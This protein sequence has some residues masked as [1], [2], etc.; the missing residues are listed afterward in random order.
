MRRT[1]LSQ[2]ARSAL[3]MVSASSFVSLV[4][5]LIAGWAI[6]EDYVKLEDTN[7]R[8][9]LIIII[10]EFVAQSQNNSLELVRKQ[11]DLHDQFLQTKN[12]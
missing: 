12:L 11:T 5:M 1:K 8:F 10:S 9:L 6:G 7:Y 2:R 3:Y 4:M